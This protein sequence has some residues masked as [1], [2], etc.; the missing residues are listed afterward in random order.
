MTASTLSADGPDAA[1]HRTIQLHGLPD[2][3]PRKVLVGEGP[4]ATGLRDSW[5]EGPHSPFSGTYNAFR[6]L[7]GNDRIDWLLVGG[8]IHVHRYQTLA[9]KVDGRWP[10]DH[11]P[12]TID[13]ELR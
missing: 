4:T 9:D 8:P 2:D 7:R 1:T 6:G 13:V 11:Y 10:S 3:E 5:S 12:I